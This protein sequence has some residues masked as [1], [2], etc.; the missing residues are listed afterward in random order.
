MSSKDY[1]DPRFTEALKIQ[2]KNIDVCIDSKFDTKNPNFSN[3]FQLEFSEERESHKRACWNTWIS[4]YNFQGFFMN[5][6]DM[7]VKNKWRFRNCKEDLSDC[8]NTI[9]F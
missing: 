6:G 7:I 2:W 8:K 3:Y 5:L 4:P 1:T 9:R